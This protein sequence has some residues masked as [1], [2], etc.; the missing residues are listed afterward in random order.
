[1][2]FKKEGKPEVGELVLCTVKKILPHAAFVYLDEYNHL[3]AMLHVSEI[4]SRWV[5][6][7][8][9]YIS[10]G[11]KIVCKVLEVKPN[12]HI[13]VSLKR[14]TNAETKRKLNEVK[15]EQRME[16][17]IEAIARRIKVE[18]KEGLEKVGRVLVNEFG[19]LADFYSEVRSEGTEVIN[20]LDLPDKWKKELYEQISEQLKSQFVNMCRQIKVSSFEGDAVKR[21]RKVFEKMY[22]LA[23]KENEIS[24]EVRHITSP[25]YLFEITAKN[26]KVGEAFIN[27]L[28]KE[29]SKFASKQ[30]VNFEIIGECK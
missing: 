8:K 22:N 14:V 12:G 2:Y 4:S 30:N 26:Y 17:L 25:K 6:N 21:I 13:D 28:G 29:I 23:K 20:E 19:S 1:M 11:K 16:K 7:I 15:A 9:D 10:Q 24:I 5:K 18:P 27:K 3:E